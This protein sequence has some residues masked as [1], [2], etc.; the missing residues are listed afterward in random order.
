LI[1][2][3]VKSNSSLS[4]I[5][6]AKPHFHMIEVL[7]VEYRC[8]FSEIFRTNFDHKK[9]KILM[10]YDRRLQGMV[11]DVET[12]TDYN[13]ALCYEAYSVV[14]SSDFFLPLQPQDLA[15]HFSLEL[16]RGVNS[17]NLMLELK[18]SNAPLVQTLCLF[19]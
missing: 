10:R 18:Q 8:F 19:N 9:K 6:N 12:A 15:D 2:R 16:R 1:K 11:K 5:A 4:N 3:K 14:Y 17:G 7:V 13:K